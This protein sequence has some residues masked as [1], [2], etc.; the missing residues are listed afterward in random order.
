MTR[1]NS[2]ETCVVHVEA[3]YWVTTI[4]QFH[5]F[6]DLPSSESKSSP[7]FSC[8]GLEWKLELSDEDGIPYSRRE[9]RLILC[10]RSNK[11]N[12]LVHY[13]FLNDRSKSVSAHWFRGALYTSCPKWT[14]RRDE[15]SNYVQNGTLSIQ[16]RMAIDTYRP[17]PCPNIFIPCNPSVCKTI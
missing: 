7:R 15:A 6:N 5:G 13:Q 12:V 2:D 9:A 17:K 14:F 11:T 10:N 1:S 3:P 8:M 16:I 4:V